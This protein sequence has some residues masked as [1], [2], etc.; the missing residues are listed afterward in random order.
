M[1]AVQKKD[2]YKYSTI[3]DNT[4]SCN[5]I[6]MPID[7]L[8]EPPKTKEKP[9]G[10]PHPEVFPPGVHEELACVL[11]TFLKPGA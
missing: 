8:I 10:F 9:G 5:T 6:I 4:S 7:G 1:I 3:V 11:L 2:N